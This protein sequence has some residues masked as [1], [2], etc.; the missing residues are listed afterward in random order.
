[1]NFTMSN[2]ARFLG[3]PET[4]GT[5]NCIGIA[6]PVCVE[7]ERE[8]ASKRIAARQQT[9]QQL[10]LVDANQPFVPAPAAL[11]TA[12]KAL[13]FITAGN[14]Y[15]TIRS[16]KTGVRY[17]YRVNVSKP[18]EKYTKATTFVS[19]LTGPQNTEDYSYLG[20]IS[21]GQFRLTRASRMKADSTPVKAFQWVWSAL[22]AGKLP[23]ATEIWHEGRCGRCGRKLTVPES[24]EAGIGPECAGKVGL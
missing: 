10:P 4:P 18:N 24:I 20:M 21:N 9:P 23:P 8:A 2:A 11:E 12:A 1:M 13:Q 15:F 3:N 17:T 14:A 19:L 7:A 22:Q 6:C 5:H 16:Q